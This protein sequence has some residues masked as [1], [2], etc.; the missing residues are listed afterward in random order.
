MKHTPGPWIISANN[1]EPNTIKIGTGEKG[2]LGVAQSFGD[3]QEEAE[4]NANLIIAAPAMLEALKKTLDFLYDGTPDSDISP[5][6]MNLRITIESA[7]FEAT[8]GSHEALDSPP[9]APES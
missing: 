3:T 7:I 1:T 9:P 2:W 6:E 8:G 5:L 4:A